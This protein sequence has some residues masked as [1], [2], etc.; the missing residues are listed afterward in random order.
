VLGAACAAP[1]PISPTS[2]SAATSPAAI[3]FLDARRHIRR[4]GPVIS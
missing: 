4:A 3:D 2:A 1:G